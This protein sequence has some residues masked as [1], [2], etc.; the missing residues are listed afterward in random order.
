MAISVAR[1]TSQLD[2]LP[3]DG[4][5][6]V[7]DLD[8][9]LL[10]TDTLV[11]S[12]FLLLKHRP[13]ALLSLPW[14][15][16]RGRAQMKQALE[17]RALVFMHALPYRD[18]LL[19]FLREQ[20]L[21]G[22]R[23]VLATAADESIAA[24]VAEE[25]GIFEFVF[26]SNGES[27][28]RGI[29]KRE[30]LVEKFGEKG[31]DYIGDD[32]DISIWT[33][34]R[35]GWLV[36]PS[37][38][39]KSQVAHA[40]HLLGTFDSAPTIATYL[41]QLR[42]SH[43][44]KNFLIF[45]PWVWVHRFH[46]VHSLAQSLTAFVAFSLCASAI[47]VLNDLLDL[48]AD[49]MHPTKKERPLASGRLPLMHA[50]AMVPLLFAAALVVANA[51][52]TAFQLLLLAYATTM[53]LYSVWL[54]SL[55]IVDVLILAAGY[56]ARVAAGAL[57]IQVAASQWLVA[58]SVCLFF[59]LALLKRYADLLSKRGV[60]RVQAE[61]RGYQIHD[62]GLIMVQGI[63]SGYIAVL[64]LALY[65]TTTAIQKQPPAI[66]GLY[67][68]LCLLLFYWINY[69]WLAGRRGRMHHDPF[70]FAAHDPSSRWILI[71]ATITMLAAR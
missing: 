34:A 32:A 53:L 39:R 62:R 67:W 46:D 57:A 9:A 61:I 28:L 43:W 35:N 15:L 14:N 23:L 63:V 22:R 64:I 50:L 33:A 19:A 1:A 26:A 58:F 21:N 30:L 48:S 5:P 8:D 12:I 41:E 70:A 42:P 6:L 71:A 68:L 69:M 36:G 52:P 10:R 27:N 60:A 25:L 29:R 59:S 44:L 40:T 54:K 17:R 49:R 55:P 47:Y 20:K 37:G 24:R 38:K 7:V 11:E 56:A 3:I 18:E 4:T 66:A 45:W 16:A 13:L 31:F 2:S 65:S 51:L